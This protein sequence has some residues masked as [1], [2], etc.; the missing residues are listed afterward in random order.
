MANFFKKLFGNKSSNEENGLWPL[1]DKK[2][3]VTMGWDFLFHVDT[4]DEIQT[5]L[6]KGAYDAAEMK[7]KKFKED[8][9]SA[10]MADLLLLEAQHRKGDI[11]ACRETYGNTNRMELVFYSAEQ[12]TPLVLE[13]SE[14][15]LDLSDLPMDI[16]IAYM[17]ASECINKVMRANPPERAYIIG[18]KALKAAI[19]ME[20]PLFGGN[21]KS[22]IQACIKAG[23]NR[24]PQSPSLL[25]MKKEIQ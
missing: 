17:G 10:I 15:L 6:V 25:K 7:A 19:D 18:A 9:S 11:N 8:F 3:L 14:A 1:F 22:M 2:E 23:L 4:W 20:K 5:L 12:K 16:Q 21:E 13:Y 24:Y